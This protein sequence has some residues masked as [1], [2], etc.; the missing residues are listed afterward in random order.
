MWRT[1]FAFQ[2]WHSRDR[3][4]ALHAAVHPGI[5]APAHAGRGPPHQVQPVRLD[6]PADPALAHRSRRRRALRRPRR[7]RRF[8]PDRSCRPPRH[9]PPSANPRR[10]VD[11]RARARR[12]R[13]ADARLD[14]RRRNLRRQRQR[15]RADPRPARRRL[16]AVGRDRAQGQGFRPSQYVLRQHRREQ[17]GV[18]HADDARRRAAE[19]HRRVLRRHAGNGSVDDLLRVRTG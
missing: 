12:R 4:E 3:T 7:R 19:P 2:N 9:A 16:G 11:D 13:D 5:P 15:A 1:T 18:V 8:R 10:R 14:R 17:M 6:R